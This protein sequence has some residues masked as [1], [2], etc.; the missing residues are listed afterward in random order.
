MCIFCFDYNTINNIIFMCKLHFE[1]STV[2]INEKM[3]FTCNSIYKK[4]KTV[5]SIYNIYK[6]KKI[7]H[8]LLNKIFLI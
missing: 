5:Y 4:T 6:L 8:E 7:K 1:L 3:I 2:K